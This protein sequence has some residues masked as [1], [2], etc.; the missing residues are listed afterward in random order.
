MI[1]INP[2]TMAAIN[3]GV[4]AAGTGLGFMGQKDAAAQNNKAIQAR[5]DY[6]QQMWGY[7]EQM[8]DFEYRNALKIYGM[9]QKEA[10]LQIEEYE[11]AFANYYMDEQLQFNELVTQA[12]QQALQSSMQTDQAVGASA[13]S[14]LS[15]GATGRRAGVQSANI[16]LMNAMSGAERA[17]RLAFAEDMRDERIDRNVRTTNLRRQMAFNAIGPRP[18]RA[19]SAPLPYMEA[20]DPGPSTVGLLG[21]LVN[22]A[23]GALGMYSRLKAPSAGNIGGGRGTQQVSGIGPVRNSAM[24]GAAIS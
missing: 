13:A 10:E 1:V 18:E 12:K 6:N 22:D 4:N 2:A 8:K 19:P 7:G 21:G 11:N 14:A 24:Y 16:E 15:R 17:R 20:M 3:F 9:R 23:G 5:N